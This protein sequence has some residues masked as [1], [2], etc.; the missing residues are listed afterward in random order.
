MPTHKNVGTA[1]TVVELR[2]Q[3]GEL[4][5]RTDKNLHAAIGM[6]FNLSTKLER[7]HELLARFA[8]AADCEGAL[9]RVD[10]SKLSQAEERQKR[11][12]VVLSLADLRQKSA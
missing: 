9:N 1:N 3:I 2:K 11:H 12:G 6:V 10:R 5:E 4:E 7:M 8:A